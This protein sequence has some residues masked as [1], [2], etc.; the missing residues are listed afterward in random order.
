MTDLEVAVIE[1]DKAGLV[2]PVPANPDCCEKCAATARLR[3]AI[4]A[5][6]APE[7]AQ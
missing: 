5:A 4:V 6:I 7:A 1:F 3:A 2:G